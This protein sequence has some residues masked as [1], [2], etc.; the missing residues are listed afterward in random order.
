MTESQEGPAAPDEVRALRE[1]LAQFVVQLTALRGNLKITREEF[2]ERLDQLREDLDQI[3]ANAPQ[4]PPAIAWWT[5]D[6][7]QREQARTALATFTA[8]VLRRWYPSYM[9]EVAPCILSHP[10]GLVEL[11]NIC[12]E[13]RRVYPQDRRASLDGALNLH[14]RYLPGV[15][16]RLSAVTRSC[17]PGMCSASGG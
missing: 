4:G 17:G 6:D 12:G 1:S 14:E 10:E 13:F 11:G 15:I 8:E 3:S 9:A 5:L 7:Q 2:A 16:R